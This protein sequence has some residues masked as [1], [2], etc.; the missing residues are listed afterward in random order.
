MPRRSRRTTGD[1]PKRFDRTRHTVS[2]RQTQ[3]Q[4]SS[5]LHSTSKILAD[6]RARRARQSNA[7]RSPR[8]T[9]TPLMQ[10]VAKN[11]RNPLLTTSTPRR[12]SANVVPALQRDAKKNAPKATLP[13]CA[14]NKT[15]RRRAIIANGYGGK[16]GYRNYSEHTSCP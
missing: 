2:N 9:R 8:T 1:R 5:G 7:L 3:P 13:E 4:P 6:S 14:R 16:N 12:M 15:A 11:R 10:S